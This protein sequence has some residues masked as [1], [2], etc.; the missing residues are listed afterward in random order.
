[1][2]HPPFP[3]DLRLV[4][5]PVELRP[6]EPAD[7]PALM[8]LAEATPE[9][10]VWTYTPR[11]P[12]QAAAYFAKA[13]RQRDEG[14]G[15]TFAV[16]RSDVGRIVGTTRFQDYEAAHRRCA[17]GYSWYAP[18]HHRDGTNRRCKVL[19]LD[20]AFDRL[21]VERVQFTTDAGNLVSRRS[22][23]R[24]GAVLEGTLRRQRVAPDGTVRDSTVYSILAEEWRGVRA[25]IVGGLDGAG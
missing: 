15:F 7:V 16:V 22:L 4:L 8:A 18:N 1:V 12:E 19:M 21:G 25:G 10:F 23:E 17:I 3:P 24:L 11:T 5:G 14:S 13:F 2:A 9:A 6:L 20:Y